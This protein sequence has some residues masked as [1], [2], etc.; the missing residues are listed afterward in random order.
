MAYSA[1]ILCVE[2][3]ENKREC[4]PTAEHVTVTV[5][6]KCQQDSQRVYNVTFRRVRVILV[7]AEKQNVLHILSV[8]L[9]V[10]VCVCV[11][12]YVCVCMCVC[13]CVCVCVGGCVWCV[14]V[15]VVCVCS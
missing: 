14:C 9:C 5:Q 4:A 6:R 15:C 1:L 12:V 2:Y 13:L 3:R 8:C 10:C 11:C 7:A